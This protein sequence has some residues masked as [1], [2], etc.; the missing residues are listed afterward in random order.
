MALDIK[1]HLEALDLRNHDFYSN[2]SEAEKKEFS[3]YIL[4]RYS[5]NVSA[6]TDFQEW[7]LETTNEYVN[8]DHWVLSKNHKN[9]L[10]QLFASCGVGSKFYHPYLKAASKEKVIKLEKLLAELNPSSKI[11]D[12][13]LAAKLMTK[14]E[15]EELFDSLGFDSKQRKEYE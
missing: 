6:G 15:K 1:R 13:K 11:S 12:I 5:S 9:L 8:K 7:F 3:P 14:K 2:L 10:W 4:M